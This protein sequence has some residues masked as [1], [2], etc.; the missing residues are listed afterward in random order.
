MAAAA[1]AVAMWK[2][3][4]SVSLA[5]DRSVLKGHPARRRVQEFIS[6]LSMLVSP[7]SVDAGGIVISTDEHASLSSVAISWNSCQMVWSV[8]LRDFVSIWAMICR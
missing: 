3:E 1:R 7:V 8:G 5:R 6:L 2:S 4:T